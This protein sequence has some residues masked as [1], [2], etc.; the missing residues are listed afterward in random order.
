MEG[1]KPSGVF[2]DAA[3]DLVARH[4]PQPLAKERDLALAKA[5]EAL[6]SL[7]ITA[8]ADMGSTLEDWQSFRRAGDAGW[9]NLRIFSYS[10]GLDPMLAITAGEPTPWLYGDRLRMAGV[11]LYTDGALGSRG[12]WL[13]QPYAD[14][15]AERGLQFLD[16]TKL[17]NLMSRAAM[18]MAKQD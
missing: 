14:K 3:A 17:R 11:K 6:L 1:A 4:A 13:K 8:I 2:I 18:A 7:G 16:D 15:P 10:A 5:Q 12:A 9:L